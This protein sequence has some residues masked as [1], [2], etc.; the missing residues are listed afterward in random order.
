MYACQCRCSW[1]VKT[2]PV[3]FSHYEGADCV[4]SQLEN[5][6]HREGNTWGIHM[7]DNNYI[8]SLRL[9]KSKCKLMCTERNIQSYQLR[10]SRMDDSP[11][12]HLH[13]GQRLT[14]NCRRIIESCIGSCMLIIGGNLNIPTGYLKDRSMQKFSG[15]WKLPSLPFKSVISQVFSI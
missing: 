4:R 11:L 8:Y 1:I 5:S 9:C 12:T 2:H 3:H 7:Q 6:P 10:W 14:W 13:F 15:I